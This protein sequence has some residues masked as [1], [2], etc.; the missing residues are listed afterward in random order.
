M[1]D[2]ARPRALAACFDF[3]MYFEQAVGDIIPGSMQVRRAEYFVHRDRRPIDGVD[4]DKGPNP[5]IGFGDA[6]HDNHNCSRSTR[7]TVSSGQSWGAVA[8]ALP[9]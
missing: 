8:D 3:P 6:D 9:A 7:K 4:S 5:D 2:E 1:G